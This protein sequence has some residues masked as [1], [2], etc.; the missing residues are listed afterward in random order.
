MTGELT[1]TVHGVTYREKPRHKD[2]WRLFMNGQG[3]WLFECQIG[4]LCTSFAI[5]YIA[6]AVDSLRAGLVDEW[7]R[8][9]IGNAETPEALQRRTVLLAAFEPVQED[10][11][12]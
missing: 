5:P 7:K 6:P 3:E 10:D 9:V 12:A 4:P 8:N 2:P 1:F 11:H